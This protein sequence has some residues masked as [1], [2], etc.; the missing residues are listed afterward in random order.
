M[1]VI[2]I[3]R[4]RG[5]EGPA[6][7]GTVVW[8]RRR[9]PPLRIFIGVDP[10][11]EH[12][13]RAG[14]DAFLVAAAPVAMHHRERILDVE[15]TLDQKLVEG[16]VSAMEMVAGWYRDVRPVAIR[17][18]FDEHREST[19]AT[20][21]LL[22]GGID[23]LATLMH[24]RRR[25]RPD[26]VEELTT[27]IV[28]E[29]GF[30]PFPMGGPYA[31]SVMALAEDLGVE[32]VRVRT[33][34]RALEPSNAFF[35][36]RYHGAFLAAIGHALS[37]SISRLLIASGGAAA[38][39]AW[40]S[41]PKLDPLYSSSR[42]TVVHHLPTMSRLEKTRLV[43]TWP[44]AMANL[45]VCLRSEGGADGGPNCG[46]CE[47]CMRTALA[48]AAI[49]VPPPEILGI[50]DLSADTVLACCRLN[51]YYVGFYTPLVGPLRAAGRDDLAGAVEQVI[52]DRRRTD[53]VPIARLKRFE[54][55]VL[56]GRVRRLVRLMGRR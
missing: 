25:G 26:T 39:D 5:P 40:G 28:I 41:H 42:L 38:L 20:A 34:L 2:D 36:F 45:R 47:K 16:V 6:V 32:L 37:S 22:S 17:G 18:P 35:R 56:G 43:A 8:E 10:S 46:R 49:G 7:A 21:G 14:A 23:S 11:H 54:R 44:V 29:S 52:A 4:E 27:A 30:D 24:A 51:E 3:G 12:M 1:R 15:G 55:D 48:F 53:R 19:G 50:G 33:N 31:H 9:R 13:S